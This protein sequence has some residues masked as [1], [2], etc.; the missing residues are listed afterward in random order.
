MRTEEEARGAN[1]VGCVGKNAQALQRM[2]RVQHGKS[3][4]ASTGIPTANV[5]PFEAGMARV[6]AMQIWERRAAE[7]SRSARQKQRIPG[8][9]E[10]TPK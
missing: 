2:A 4:H 6:S 8:M 1:G 9:C 3:T 10:K 7:G 5:Q